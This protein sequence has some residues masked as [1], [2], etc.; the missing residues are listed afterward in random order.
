MH[1]HFAELVRDA[2]PNRYVRSYLRQFGLSHDELHGPETNH[3]LQEKLFDWLDDS[4]VDRFVLLAMDRVHDEDGR[5]D[6]TATAWVA[7]NDF[8]AELAS[9]H[10]KL[11][12]GA[13]VHPY[14]R[15]AIVELERAIARGACL[16][17]WIPS[18]QHIRLDD[19]RCAAFY[20]TLAAAKVPLLVHTGNEHVSS[21]SRN[22]WNDPALL[23]HP[24][25]RDVTVI[26]AHCGARMFLHE[27]CGFKTFCRMALEHERLYGDLSA[28]G[29]P[30]R[31][32]PLRRIQRDSRLL[33]KVVYGSDFPVPVMPWWFVLSLGLKA[34]RE[35]A[36]MV[37][38]LERA[39]ALM[40]RMELPNEVFERV[41][42]LLRSTA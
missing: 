6:P 25:R 24:L 22:H 29:F 23:T 19:P 21:R 2:V 14:R 15:D 4:S 7:D 41:D 8:I 5:S 36:A 37:N 12:F 27:R 32:L 33:A 20:E 39:Y 18:A 38:P 10:R 17:K 13:S 26:A 3:L 30:T 16:V 34:V 11:L 9:R 31:I 28:F 42:T 35:V 1:V 40:R